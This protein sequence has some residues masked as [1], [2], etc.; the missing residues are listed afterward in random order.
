M[1]N[2]FNFLR[3]LSLGGCFG[4]THLTFYG[5]YHWGDVLASPPGIIFFRQWGGRLILL[6]GTCLPHPPPTSHL[7]YDAKSKS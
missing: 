1:W 3:Y 4:G 2:T 5:I 7:G 6:G